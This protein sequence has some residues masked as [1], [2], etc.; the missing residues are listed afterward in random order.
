LSQQLF[1]MPFAVS[2]GRIEEGAP[3]IDCGLKRF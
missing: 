2:V 3:E 1:A